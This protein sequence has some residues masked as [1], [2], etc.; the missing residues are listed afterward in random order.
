MCVW[1]QHYQQQQQQQAYMQQQQQRQAQ[2]AAAAQQQQRGAVSFRVGANG[3]VRF[4]TPISALPL[5]L[6]VLLRLL[7]LL[8]VG[9]F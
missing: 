5:H 7:C 1:A 2:A 9:S 8:L 4:L 3:P 6:L